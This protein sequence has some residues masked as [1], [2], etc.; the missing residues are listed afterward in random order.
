MS[1]TLTPTHLFSF[2][3]PCARGEWEPFL[4]ALDPNVHWVIADPDPSGEYPL[5]VYNVDTWKEK[6]RAPLA[7]AL[8]TPI[9]MVAD[10]IEIVG[11]KAI[12]ECS[13]YATQKNGKPYNNKFCW[14]FIF[15]AKTGKVV[16]IR[17]YINTALVREVAAGQ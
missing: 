5:G 2:L 6:I 7:K 11:L 15:D 14:I 9:K 4:S 3:D 12:V 13:G 16:K 8:A 17:E 10:E 1:F